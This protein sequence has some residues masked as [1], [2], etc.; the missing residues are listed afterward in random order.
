M[1]DSDYAMSDAHYSSQGA[2]GGDEDYSD[3][4]QS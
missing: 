2:N 3:D 1:H 4:S